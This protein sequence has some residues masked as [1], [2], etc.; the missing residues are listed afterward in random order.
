MT[1]ERKPHR[2]TPEFRHH[3]DDEPP[4]GDGIRRLLLAVTGILLIYFGFAITSPRP[5]RSESPDNL[6]PAEQ[7]NAAS[8]RLLQRELPDLTGTPQR[9]A[10]WRDRIL[11][12][13]FWAT[14]CPPC[15]KEMPA[16]T[17]V[18]QAFASQPVQFVGIGIDS[19]DKMQAFAAEQS[20]PYP[21]LVGT[22]AESALMAELGNPGQVLPFTLILGRQGEILYQKTGL[23]DEDTLTTA[24][25]NSLK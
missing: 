12:I 21:L 15:R 24:L 9:L 6:P 20:I 2:I 23:I 18:A 17:R 16:L 3:H 11:V 22:A 14:W 25:R 1:P 7:L 19:A 10:H 4:R 5:P 8:L 13:N